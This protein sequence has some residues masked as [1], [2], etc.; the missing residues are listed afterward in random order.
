MKRLLFLVLF[1]STLA[2]ALPAQS[3]L[4]KIEGKDLPAAS[5][6]FGTIHAICKDEVSI[7]PAVTEA[8]DSSAQIALELDLDDP[9]LIVEMGHISYMPGDSTLND[10]FSAEDYA[11]LNTW[12]TD[13]VGMSLDMMN[14]MRPLF[15]FGLLIGKVIGCTPTSYEEI[16]MGMALQQEKEL[17]GLETPTEQLDAFSSIPMARQADM[18]LEMVDHM[19]STRLE[20]RRLA[21]LYRAQDL[22]GLRS[23]VLNSTVEYGRY[24]E[25]LLAQRNTTWIPRLLRFARNKSTFF[26]VGA[27]HLPGEDGVIALLRAEGYKV[28][29]VK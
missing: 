3:L 7:P 20:F 28:T 24:N 15:L 9:A 18:V 19:D 16:F 1:L 6:I 23:F 25:A 26:A 21:D 5:W 14:S 29:P 11:R 2:P 12:L 17:V 13:S 22:E 27:G 4:W 10:V 8:V